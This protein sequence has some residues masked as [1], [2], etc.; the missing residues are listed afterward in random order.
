MGGLGNRRRKMYH[1]IEGKDF[2][3]AMRRE[4]SDIINQLV[5]YINSEDVMEVEAHLVGSGAK[6][7]ETQNA[8][9]PVD[10]DYNLN[11]LETYECSI[12]D[13][14]YIQEY[15]RKSFNY[16]LKR[17]GWEDCHDSKSVF[18]TGYRCFDDF[19]TSFKIDLAIVTEDTNGWYRGIHKK[20]GFVQKD[21][22]YW[23]P[24][25]QSKGL[26]KRV[27]AIKKNGLWQEVRKVYLKKKN[28]YLVRN[29]YDHPSFVCYIETINEIW[30]SNFR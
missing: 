13:G 27:D 17:N 10:L 15:V 4:C 20:T 3:K 7:L 24:A 29:D 22:Y 8:D 19:D 25:P 28:M 12:N 26:D 9:E 6:H 21:E 11:I 23:V 1:Y 30:Y 18:S 2:L 14:R 5:Q 16:I